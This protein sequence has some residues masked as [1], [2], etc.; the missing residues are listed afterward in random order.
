M[1]KADFWQ[2]HLA[3]VVREGISLSAYAKRHGISP[4]SLY[5]WHRKLKSAQG[6]MAVTVRPAG[7]FI[8]LRVSDSVS[9]QVSGR[10]ALVLESGMRLEMATLPAPEWILALSRAQQGVR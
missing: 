5:Y 10:C 7:G 8:A 6:A 4:K 3:A 9:S 2:G 1:A